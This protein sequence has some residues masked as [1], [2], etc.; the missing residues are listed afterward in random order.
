MQHDG[1]LAPVGLVPPAR[2]PRATDRM[3]TEYAT[4]E[5]GV[6]WTWHGT[7]LR[8]RPGSWDARGTRV[9]AVRLDQAG[10]IAYYDGRATAEEN[11]E[12]RTGV[13]RIVGLGTFEALG[14]APIAVSPTDWAA[15]AMSARSA[16]PTAAPGSTTRSPEPTARTSC[17]PRS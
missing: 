9:A 12:E 6:D 14:D 16:C 1:R 11:W 10:P 2:R 7:A 13:A 17:A 5:D 3:T 8:G 4:S 15:C